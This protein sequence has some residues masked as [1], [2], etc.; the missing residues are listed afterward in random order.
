M[1]SAKVKQTEAHWA[2]TPRKP[3]KARDPESEAPRSGLVAMIAEYRQAEDALALAIDR[4][5]AAANG[6][7]HG[8]LAGMAAEP[9]PP[10]DGLAAFDRRDATDK[11]AP[12]RAADA[13]FIEEINDVEF[14]IVAL[15]GKLE[16]LE[17]HILKAVPKDRAQ[18]LAKLRFMFDLLIVEEDQQE[19]F[20][21]RV[22][23]R[24]LGVLA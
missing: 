12:I 14:S 18:A 15:T 1:K 11:I 10:V 24:C 20:T 22:I 16:E 9:R 19:K 6:Y 5:E 3:R 4:Q 8:G 17:R 21:D 13:M 23:D 2:P 7:F